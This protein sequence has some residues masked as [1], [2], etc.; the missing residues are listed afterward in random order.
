MTCGGLPEIVLSKQVDRKRMLLK[1]YLDDVLFKDVAM[2]HQIRDVTLLR[3]IAIHLLTQ[4]VC[5]FSANRIGKIF[6]ISLETASNYCNF[7]RESF[8][9]D[10]LY[11]F[12]LKTAERN[13][14]PKKYMLMIWDLGKWCMY[15][16]LLNTEKLAETV[17][18]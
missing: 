17:V 14:N 13:R 18:Y 16:I 6:E 3:N 2:R 1:Q 9:V 15:Q 7:F 11:Y 5:L 12:S 4:M 10:F 8:S